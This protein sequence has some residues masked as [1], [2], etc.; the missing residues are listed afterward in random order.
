[1]AGRAGRV[2]Q[3]CGLRRTKGAGQSLADSIM[4]SI[5]PENISPIYIPIARKRECLTLDSFAHDSGCRFQ[6]IGVRVFQFRCYFESVRR[7]QIEQ[8]RLV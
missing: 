8:A 7:I 5:G 1:M 3:Q 6:G 4:P 2:A